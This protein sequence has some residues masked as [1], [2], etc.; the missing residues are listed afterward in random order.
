MRRRDLL[1]LGAVAMASPALAHPKSGQGD[2][3]PGGAAAPPAPAL[4]ASARETILL[5]ADW[6]FHPWR[7]SLAQGAR[8]QSDL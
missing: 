7:H 6:R 2:T 4:E 3:R 1:T 5:D 8:R